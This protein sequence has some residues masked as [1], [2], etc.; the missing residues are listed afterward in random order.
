MKTST[1]TLALNAS[2]AD[3]FAFL[4]NIE[5]PAEVGNSLL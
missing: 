3:V 1:H 4:S 5:N 2:K